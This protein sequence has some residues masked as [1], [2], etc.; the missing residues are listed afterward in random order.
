MLR[1]SVVQ[2]G[3]LYARDSAVGNFRN[4]AEPYMA[5]SSGG[6]TSGIREAERIVL[7]CSP[8]HCRSSVVAYPLE[9]RLLPLPLC[10]QTVQLLGWTTRY[11]RC[12][13]MEMVMVMEA[14]L[15]R[16]SKSDAIPVTRPPDVF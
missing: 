10:C 3:Q 7:F 6:C 4:Q 15:E 5:S 16:K 11:G 8:L 2:P 13:Q 9:T 12:M 1:H 14:Y